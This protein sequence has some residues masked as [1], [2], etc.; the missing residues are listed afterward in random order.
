MFKEKQNH[1]PAYVHART[2][3]KPI[4]VEGFVEMSHS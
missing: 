2:F 1:I 4:S 3:I